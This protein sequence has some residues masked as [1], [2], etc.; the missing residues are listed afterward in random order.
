MNIL[1]AVANWYGCPYGL[2]KCRK[3]C[4]NYIMVDPRGDWKKG[5]GPGPKEQRTLCNLL[6][7]LNKQIMVKTKDSRLDT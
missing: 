5:V 2:K 1:E 6:S 3:N 4:R 7:D